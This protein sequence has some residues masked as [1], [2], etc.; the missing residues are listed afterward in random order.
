MEQRLEMNLPAGLDRL[1]KGLAGEWKV[2]ISMQGQDGSVV[3]GSGNFVA[4]EISLGRGIN[5]IMSLELEGLGHY[6]ENVLWSYDQGTNEVVNLSVTS[7]GRV[8]YH[9]GE[10]SDNSTLELELAGT[11]K[12]KGATEDV[13]LS[14]SSSE[15]VKGHIVVGVN[16]RTFTVIDYVLKRI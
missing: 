11:Q 15:E 7:D 1:I 13:K 14:I 4:K 6:E 9:T 5:S 2:E 16:G 3:K 10:W 8:L 12:G